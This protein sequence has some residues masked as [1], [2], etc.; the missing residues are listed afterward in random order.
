MVMEWRKRRQAEGI[1]VAKKL[2][3]YRGRLPGTTKGQ[4][5]RARELREHGL[6]LLEIA[7]AMGVS[8]STVIRYLR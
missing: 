8:K 5:G 6:K 7:T 4:P 3:K 2:G 1:L